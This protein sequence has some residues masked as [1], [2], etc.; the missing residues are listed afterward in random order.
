MLIITNGDSAA[1][2]LQGA[3]VLEAAGTGGEFLPWRDVLHDG[4]VP[5]GHE[6]EEMSD[7]RAWFISSCGWGDYDQVREEFRARDDTLGDF[8]AHEEVVLWFEHD[9]YDQLQ[10][11]QLLDWFSHRDVEG[12]R[13]A[14]I[15]DP[16]YIG[17]RSAQQLCGWFDHRVDVA[18]A[19]L[20]LGHRAWA[21]FTAPT[22]A[23]LDRLLE[24]D[25]EALPHLGAAVERL[26][27]E[28][29]ATTNGLARSER[30]ILEALAAGAGTFGE[31]FPATQA[32]EASIY[33]GDASLWL[34]VGRLARAPDAAVRIPDRVTG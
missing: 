8:A 31:L 12:T 5:A 19:Q 34:Y 29:P 11:L 2:A 30:Q 14:L 32:M 21:A 4:P 16:E 20:R 7:V 27:E 26:L 13:L 22:P 23:R 3:S 15:Q 28:Y 18:P 1:A 6:L 24:G 10:L 33:L 25:T 9:L 17:P